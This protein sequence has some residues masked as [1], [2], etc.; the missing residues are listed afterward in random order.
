MK[1]IKTR[2]TVTHLENQYRL[3][4]GRVCSKLAERGFSAAE[5]ADVTGLKESAIMSVHFGKKKEDSEAEEA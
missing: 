5:I 3:F 2:K 1:P 4:V